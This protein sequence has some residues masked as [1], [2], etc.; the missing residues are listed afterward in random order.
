MGMLLARLS[1]PLLY[2]ATALLL[3]YL[4]HRAVRPLTRRAAL[5]LL[6]L[7]LCFTG[8]AF[9]TGQAYGPINLAYGS[10][11][12]SAFAGDFG[13][14]PAFNS[15][16]HDLYTAIIPW[17]EAV[18][19]AFS[20]G[21]WPLLNPFVLCGDPLAGSAQPA[22]F[23]P[24]SLLALLV[25]MPF[26]LGYLAALHYLAAA[27][28][29]FLLARELDC[30]EEAAAVAAVGWMASGFVLFWLEWPL[31]MTIVHLPLVLLGVRR[32]VTTPGRG[33][34][35]LL[36]AGL[37]AALLAGHPESA[38]HLV[39]LGMVYGLVQLAGQERRVWA[40]AFGRGILAGAL[41]LGL[42]AIFT[43]PLLDTLTQTFQWHLRQGQTS[44]VEGAASFDE[45]GQRLLPSLV[46]FVYGFGAQR[47]KAVP[48]HLTPLASAYAGSL[49]LALAL[50]GL[51]RSRSRERWVWA[52]LL[53][54][55]LAA[56]GKVP[57]FY[58]LLAHVPPFQI[59]LND[60]L[61]ATGGLALALLAALGAEAW[62]RS[63]RPRSL[64]W[65]C[66]A[67]TAG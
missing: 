36:T 52:G 58:E 30:R 45:V 42:T 20:L 61:I 28:G 48:A 37:S 31:G 57:G 9:V 56:G 54:L 39:G 13:V 47:I 51:A 16:L 25:P 66:L 60:R 46:P 24:L 6:L 33:S 49:L 2:L 10:E 55:A 4:A 8:R 12:L 67:T 5:V 62:L 1:A 53:V 22:P 40:G 43:F 32:C 15:T 23:Y 34:V 59:T 44:H 18:R 7:P 29:A 35:L 19:H 17:H 41:A 65:V 14:K 63:E 3:L 50:F 26:A 38:A 11:P 21:E 27:L 64:A